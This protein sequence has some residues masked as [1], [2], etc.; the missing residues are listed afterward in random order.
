[1]V[2]DAFP[3]NVIPKSLFDPAVVNFLG[4]KPFVDSNTA[5][6]ATATGPI[7]NLLLNTIKHVRRTR[8]DGKVDHQF[9]PITNLR[10]L[11]QAGIGRGKAITRRSSTGARSTRTPSLRPWITSTASS[12]TCLF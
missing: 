11:F 12:P 3:G 5:G 6:T 1:V 9:T 10:P 2:R 7:D 4:H 8:W